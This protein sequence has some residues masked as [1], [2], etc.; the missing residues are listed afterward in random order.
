MPKPG[1]RSMRSDSSLENLVEDGALLTVFVDSERIA[2][3]IR[4]CRSAE[5]RRRGVLGQPV[6]TRERGALL[7]M[8]HSRRGRAGWLTSIHMFGVP[9]PLAVAWLD[10][11]GEVVWAQ[12]ARPW[13]PYYAS[14]EPASYVLEVHP[15]HLPLLQVGA[16]VAWCRTVDVASSDIERRK[17]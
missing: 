4:C 9:F 7:I 10:E 11:R 13:R 3:E 14:P 1:S 8:P 16:R 2:G 6:L 15:A 5:L 12:L 17:S